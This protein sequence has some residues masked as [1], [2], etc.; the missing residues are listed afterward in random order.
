LE[1]LKEYPETSDIPVIMMTAV[2]QRDK[3]WKSGGAVE[4]L[5]KGFT[6]AE[7]LAKVNSILTLK[8]VRL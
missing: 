1:T 6:L 3:D 4:Y 7:L 5:A 2:A 8:P